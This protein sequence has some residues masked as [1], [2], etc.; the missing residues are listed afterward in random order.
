MPWLNIL[1]GWGDLLAMKL[2]YEENILQLPHIVDMP[3]VCLNTW[4]GTWSRPGNTCIQLFGGW[5]GKIV[6]PGN[7]WHSGLVQGQFVEFCKILSQRKEHCFRVLQDEQSQRGMIDSL[8]LWELLMLWIWCYVTCW[9][10]GKMIKKEA[11][12]VLSREVRAHAPNKQ[13]MV[14]SWGSYFMVALKLLP[15][16]WHWG[17]GLT[18]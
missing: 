18:M 17:L 9:I 12:S 13:S 16:W 4:Y 2:T 1:A 10:L 5:S 6:S 15:I 7:V 14:G 8:S 3:G 11:L